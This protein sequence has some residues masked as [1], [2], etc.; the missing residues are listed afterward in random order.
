MLS[1]NYE[2][3]PNPGKSISQIEDC[4]IYFGKEKHKTV[5][6]LLKQKTLKLYKTNTKTDNLIELSVLF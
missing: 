5:I 6:D 2:I 3:Q 4:E 1:Y